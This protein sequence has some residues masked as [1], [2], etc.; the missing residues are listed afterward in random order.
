MACLMTG[1]NDVGRNN[2]N[3]GDAKDIKLIS[4]QIFC[5]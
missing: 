4:S 3:S 1:D 5:H 2:L